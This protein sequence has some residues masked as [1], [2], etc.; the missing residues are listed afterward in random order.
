MFHNSHHFFKQITG[1]LGFSFERCFRL[2]NKKICKRDFSREQ[3][4]KSYIDMALVLW[5]SRGLQTYC[6]YHLLSVQGRLLLFPA[7]IV[8]SSIKSIVELERG[9]GNK[10]VTKWHSLLFIAKFSL[11]FFYWINAPQTFA[12]FCLI[13]NYEKV[14]LESFP[15]FSLLV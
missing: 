3:K 10:Q 14:D 6:A 9:G 15:G 8:V 5:F 2:N 12:S 13:F 4:Y 11:F 7:T 1:G